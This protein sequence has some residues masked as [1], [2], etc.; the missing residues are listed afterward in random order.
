MSEPGSA[1]E[2]L[3]PSPEPLTA[4]ARTLP[5]SRRLGHKLLAA[6]IVLCSLGVLG[7]TLHDPVTA[8][9]IRVPPALVGT[10]AILAALGMFAAWAIWG[11]RA[12]GFR[13]YAA[14]AVLFVAVD[15]YR[16]FSFIPHVLATHWAHMNL[17][18]A[19][20]G[21][22]GGL[23]CSQVMQALILGLGYWYLSITRPPNAGHRA[24]I[25][26]R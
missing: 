14:L 1:L 23:V 3:A 26:S 13:V 20:E 17:P 18:P 8:L 21:E 2:R 7:N 9:G 5:G 22:M 11:A 25:R 15:A 24:G 19:P 16:I 12:W 6:L 10:Q 4:T